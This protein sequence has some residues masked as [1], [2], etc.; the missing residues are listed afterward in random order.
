MSKHEPGRI[1]R[2]MIVLVIPIFIV[3]N[4]VFGNIGFN[5]NVNIAYS[6]PEPTNRID[7]STTQ[8][9]GIKDMPLEKAHAG[10]IDIAYKAVGT[11]D[12][13][14]L[15][16]PAQADMNAWDPS[17]L[18]TLSANHTV[19]VFDNRGVGNT[20]TGIKPFSIQQFANDTAGL[21]NALKIQ[22]AS[23]LGYSLGSF[24]AQQLAVTYP[25]K[26]NSLVLIASS[27]GGKESIP[28]DHRN[29]EMV[30]D[31]INKVANG[32]VV[33]P[34]EVKEVISLGLGSGWLKLHPDILETT[35]FPEAKHLFPS[36]TPNNNLKQLNAGQKW[37]A[38]DWN[39]VC[40][41]LTRI[42]VP[43]LI[44]TGT[45]DVNVPAENSFII[46]EKIP[47]SWLVQIKDAGH[48]ITAQYPD[49]INRIL[50]TFLSVT[51]QDNQTLQ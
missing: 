22:N 19:I 34:Q 11:G 14:L 20:S 30:M 44:L 3:S 42:S 46:A 48:Q 8:S 5:D 31:I 25:E 24:V 28:T 9:V 18:D 23:V 17:L 50:Q 41:D 10:D 26:V 13:I 40:E 37:F 38:S 27:C 12:P 39:G 47:G 29:L 33:P 43:T 6:Q 4:S 45:D 21:M 2:F 36:I 35:A 49:K 16:S 51:S 32:T 1:D 15:I 7:S